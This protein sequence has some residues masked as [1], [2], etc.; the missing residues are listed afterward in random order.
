[1][2][3]GSKREAREFVG[4]RP[5]NQSIVS[6]VRDHG[7]M[8]VM[9]N[10]E[11]FMDAVVWA[12]NVVY[13]YKDF[14][15]A[16]CSNRIVISLSE[17]PFLKLDVVN[18]HFIMLFYYNMKQN[19]V[20]IEQ[21]KQSLYTAARFQKIAEKDVELMKQV[22]ERMTRFRDPLSEDGFN[23][24]TDRELQGAEKQ[25]DFYSH[26]VTEEIEKFREE[27]AKSKI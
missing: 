10:K 26:L 2:R 19:F 18:A 27:C 25:Y 21:L 1:M 24:P 17:L 5:K 16:K 22:D 20:L 15:G 4:A 12:A 7:F 9:M 13:E 14:F 8:A 6:R 11:D 23:F 3:E